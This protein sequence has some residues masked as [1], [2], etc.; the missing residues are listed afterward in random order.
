MR[1]LLLL[2]LLT[3]CGVPQG[4]SP[5]VKCARQA[6]NDPSVLELYTGTS[7]LYMQSPAYQG[8]LKARERQAEMKC[9][10][11]AGLAPTGGVE[12]IRPAVC[13]ACLNP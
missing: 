8:E 9:L 4:D 11:R 12:P 2:L 10:Q 6:Q 5:Q 13:T 1:L 7:G 3:A